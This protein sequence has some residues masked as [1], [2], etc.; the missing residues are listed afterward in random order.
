MLLV[1]MTNMTHIIVDHYMVI[2]LLF[3]KI[4]GC[5]HISLSKL[6]KWGFFK[7]EGMCVTLI[8]KII[9]TTSYSFVLQGKA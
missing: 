7:R 1:V 3:L 4:Y 5:S 6:S 2:K 8:V 9:S